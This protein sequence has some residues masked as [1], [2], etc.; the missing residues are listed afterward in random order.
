[1]P[2][3]RPATCTRM[4]TG[5]ASARMR[6]ATCC[7]CC[8]PGGHDGATLKSTVPGAEVAWA[9]CKAA[10][11]CGA[12]SCRSMAAAIASPGGMSIRSRESTIGQN[13]A[14]SAGESSRGSVTT[15]VTVATFGSP[16]NCRPNAYSSSSFARKDVASPLQVTSTSTGESA[17]ESKRCWMMS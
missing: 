17:D 4:P 3:E 5:G 1:M 13:R 2:A 12:V 11:S 8:E 16:C 7:A 14:S 10:W 6:A 15:L 9:S